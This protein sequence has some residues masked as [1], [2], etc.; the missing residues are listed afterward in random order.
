MEDAV[1]ANPPGPMGRPVRLPGE[2]GLAL[3][4]GYLRDG[5]VLHPSLPAMLAARAEASGLS[6]P[7]PIA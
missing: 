2:R 3:R 6:A 7:I 5:V 4:A 1:H